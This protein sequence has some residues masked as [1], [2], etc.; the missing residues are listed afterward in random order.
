LT[1][2]K[3]LADETKAE[4]QR[5]AAPGCQVLILGG[6][7][8][9]SEAAEKAIKNLGIE[10]LTTK[11]VAGANRDETMRAVY[12]EGNFPAGGTIIV[13]TG[14][15][16]ADVL[17]ISPYAYAAKAPIILTKKNGS[18]TPEAKA[19][20]ENEAKPSKVIIIGGAGV[21]TEATENYLKGLSEGVQVMRLAGA[22]RYATSAEIMKWELGLNAEAPFQPDVEMH[23]DGMGIATGT[24][25]AD[26][27]GATS[28]LGKIASPLLLVADN[29]K[30]NKAATQA[31]IDELV[32][33][34]ARDMTKGYIFGGTGAVSAQIEGW[35]N[36]AVQ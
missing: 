20:L 8:A 23:I 26:A 9:V 32:A 24:G 17:S 36:E 5:L 6:P 30:N 29:N 21:V 11:R 31:N 34:F 14:Y 22:N 16:Y 18:L 7:G 19:L 2:T 33:P 15:A 10:G 35:L 25:F 27:L 28:L 4:I 3:K 12:A 13:A 1:N